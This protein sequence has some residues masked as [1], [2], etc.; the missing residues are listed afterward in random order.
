MFPGTLEKSYLQLTST[1]IHPDFL[2]SPDQVFLKTIN[3]LF[4]NN[5]HIRLIIQPEPKQCLTHELYVNS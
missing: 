4:N 3:P 5:K 1:E 2:N